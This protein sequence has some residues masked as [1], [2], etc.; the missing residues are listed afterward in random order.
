MSSSVKMGTTKL[1]PITNPKVRF[2]SPTLL[3]S[4]TSC[5]GESQSSLISNVSTETGSSCTIPPP[6]TTSSTLSGNTRVVSGSPGDYCPWDMME[7]STDGPLHGSTVGGSISG[8]VFVG[9][10]Q[11][12]LGYGNT[13]SQMGIRSTVRAPSITSLPHQ[14]SVPIAGISTSMKQGPARLSGSIPRQS[15]PSWHLSRDICP[16]P[17]LCL[18]LACLTKTPL[19][20]SISTGHFWTIPRHFPSTMESHLPLS[21]PPKMTGPRPLR[22]SGAHSEC[23]S[24]LLF[25]FY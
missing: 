22:R 21:L 6:S 9:P 12:N 2:E 1:S 11:L 19:L 15:D 23:F 18:E 10:T 16:Y 7:A 8:A 25:T 13:P 24:F 14:G 3:S 20:P 4:Q 17:S 5:E